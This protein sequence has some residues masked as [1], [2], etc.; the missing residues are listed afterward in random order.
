MIRNRNRRR[1]GIDRP[2]RIVRSEH[3]LHDDRSRPDSPD[4]TEVCP[5][6]RR[7]SQRSIDIDQKHFSLARN[8]HIRQSR[9]SAI[10]Q[11]ADEP[12]GPR[13]NLRKERDLVERPAADQLFHPIAIIALPNSRHWRIN[14]H[15]QRVKSRHARS[16]NRCLSRA[17]PAH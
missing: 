10:E 15:D 1:S 9:Q 2:P 3:A 6:D 17:A 11:I 4:P 12:A 16:L 14:G 8:N 5:R 7:L 13:Q